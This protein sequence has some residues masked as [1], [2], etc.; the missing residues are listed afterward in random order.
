MA[1]IK[2][3]RQYKW[4]DR[5]AFDVIYESGKSMFYLDAHKLPQTVVEF[6]ETATTKTQYDRLKGYETI[7]EEDENMSG[8]VVKMEQVYWVIVKNSDWEDPD[9]F[10]M[11]HETTDLDEAVQVAKDQYGDVDCEN[12]HAFVVLRDR[13]LEGDDTPL[14]DVQPD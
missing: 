9:H 8:K 13:W 7:Y 6:I 14:V 12:N 5:D 10:I 11:A 1:K 4:F 3:V 2:F